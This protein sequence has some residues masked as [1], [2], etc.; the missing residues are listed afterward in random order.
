MA[1]KIDLAAI[2]KAGY[3][4]H[5]NGWVYSSKSKRCM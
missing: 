2:E 4:I 1:V 5:E 3:I